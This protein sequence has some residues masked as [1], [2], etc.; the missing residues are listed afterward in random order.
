MIKDF[1]RLIDRKIWWKIEDHLYNEIN[2]TTFVKRDIHNARYIDSN[3]SND[4]MG[5]IYSIKYHIV[6]KLQRIVREK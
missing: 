1:N 4:V 5:R 2:K 6:T 3:F